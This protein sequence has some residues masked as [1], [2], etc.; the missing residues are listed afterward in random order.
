[1]WSDLLYRLRALFRPRSVETELADELLAHLEQQVEKYVQSGLPHEEAARRARLEFGG[2]EQ[3]KEEC[4][5]ARGVNFIETSLRDFRC[6]LRQLLRNPGFAAAALL[7]LA[8][9]IGA[10]TAIFTVVD[11]ILLRPLPYKDP[12]RLV[13]VQERIP[14][15]L[16][17]PAALP[18][19]D[20]VTFARENHVFSDLGAFQ[21]EW[22][23]LTES[24][25]PERLMAARITASLFPLLG[26]RPLAGRL[27]MQDE[28]QPN[29][30]VALL[31]YGLWERRFGADRAIL[32][33]TIS[34]DRKSY[35]VVGV[36][37]QGFRF[38]FPGVNGSEPADLWVPMAFTPDELEDFGD[39]FNY[40]TIGRLRP[41]VTLEEANA[42][43]LA[44]AHGIQATVYKGLSGFTLEALAS[45]LQQVLVRR[46][47]PLLFILMG[48]VALVLLI[49][50]TNVASLLS[51]RAA[52]REREMAIRAALG[53]SRLR[54]ARGLL[55]ESLLLGF[56]GGTFGLLIAVCCVKVLVSLTPIT[57]LRTQPIG[58]NGQVVAF[59]VAV[60]VC[61]SLVF[62]LLPAIGLSRIDLNETL[63]EGGRTSGPAARHRARSVMVI[64]QMALSL[65][66]LASA[67][68]LIRSFER[69]RKADPGFAPQH[70]L[71][72]AVA[73]DST[74]YG[75]ASSVRSFYQR[76]LERITSLRAVRAAGTSTD[77]PVEGNW[78]HLFTVEEH[79]RQPSGRSP[80]A[81][82]SAVTGS[83]L[84]ALSIPL[85]RGRYFTPEDRAGSLRVIIVSDGLAK[86]YW[87]GENPIGK[88][89]KWGPPESHSPWLTVVG[90]V[91]D[92]KQ[93]PLD[94]PTQPHT[95]QPFAQ[96]N[97][98]AVNTIARS[99]NLAV[100]AAGSTASLTA[101]LRAQ[102]QAL[103]PGVPL[104]NVRTMDAIL[105]RSMS[106]RRFT[107]L[108]LV[109]FALAALLLASIGLYGVVAY[110]VS[111]RTH[112]FGIR[113]A[114]GAQKGDLLR[115]VIRQGSVLALAG[116]GIGLVGA[117]SLTRFLSSLLYDVK[118]T[119]P[120]T[121]AAV[122]FILIA[123]ALLASYAPARRAANVDPLVA[124]R[125][126]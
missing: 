29:R 48:S 69:L 92:V 108:L 20:V 11:A 45:P 65:V 9:G 3:V 46:V 70:V 122:S 28:D 59:A 89:I 81:N 123:V 43:V 98:A 93:G 64:T 116:V 88:R 19:P 17:D 53:A 12:Q 32:G 105:A 125:H 6:G 15:V 30:L 120:L 41:G 68:L 7:T 57:L 87:P 124:L 104:T 18:A 49:A 79:P 113:L 73:L 4:R 13:L 47:R 99:L 24:G 36:M 63:K 84:Q 23:D 112:E 42:D 54:V 40:T 35:A 66:L 34:L 94:S 61:T 85:I 22:V 91:A 80:M 50:C 10:T 118:P 2:L 119:D 71:T 51:V 83:Y 117:V 103:D 111:R 97:D 95:Y 107:T 90:V 14:R 114:L 82:H 109:A 27:F 38:P 100:L 25:P 39:N 126:E 26:V 76:L 74:A 67:G 1:M 33:K 37:P 72:A 5:D 31:G 96:L 102:L 78:N 58:L 106:P 56:L 110:S 60:S 52:E 75:Q 44:T 8:L 21:N 86:R 62:G 115:Q 55:V 121:F 16:P 101:A 77:L